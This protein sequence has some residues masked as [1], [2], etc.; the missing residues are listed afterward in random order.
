MGFISD[1]NLGPTPKIPE[2]GTLFDGPLADTS[3]VM[4]KT[5]VSR[6]LSSGMVF[7]IQCDQNGSYVLRYID[8]HGVIRPLQASTAYTS[9][10]GLV[11]IRKDGF[12]REA[13]VEFTPSAPA[14]NL[15]IEAWSYGRG[16]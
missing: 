12:V 5:V 8:S 3:T 13:Y 4:S 2:G 1:P 16:F 9:A 11:E 10:S 14:T 15:F 7:R 6:P